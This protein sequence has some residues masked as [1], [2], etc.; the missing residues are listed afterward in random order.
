MSL[1]AFRIWIGVL[2]FASVAL[3][4]LTIAVA[5]RAE[6]TR[7]AV[8][9]TAQRDLVLH[10]SALRSCERVNHLREVVYANTLEAARTEPSATYAAQLK[11]LRS[12]PGFNPADGTVDCAAVIPRP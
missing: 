5:L 7:D 12:V 8:E 10:R 4:V 3:S 2:A 1:R 9:G 6:D 11:V